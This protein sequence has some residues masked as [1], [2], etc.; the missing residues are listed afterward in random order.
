MTLG[1]VL[2]VVVLSA[3]PASS[4]PGSTAKRADATALMAKGAWAKA[5][6]VLD[7]SLSTASSDEEVSSVQLARGVC[8]AQLKQPEAAV[9][10]FTAALRLRPGATLDPKSPPAAR[11]PFEAAL[12]QRPGTLQVVAEAGA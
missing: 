10:A 3:A 2:L 6:A 8:L 11:A 5:L 7:A 12:A 4:A 1:S 9:T